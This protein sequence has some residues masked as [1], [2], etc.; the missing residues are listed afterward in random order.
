MNNKDKFLLDSIDLKHKEWFRPGMGTENV[1]PFLQ[2]LIGLTRP[3]RILEIGVGYTTPF[4][5][6]GINKNN[7]SW[8]R[9][10][11]QIKNM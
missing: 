3:Q 6:E 8:V 7:K 11:N 9:E 10:I 1:D 4:L 2:S 5:I